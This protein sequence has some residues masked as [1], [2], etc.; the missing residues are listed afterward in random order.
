[1]NNCCC[2]EPDYVY[3]VWQPKVVK[4]RKAHRCVECKETIQPGHL[5]ER[6][7]A[8]GDGRCETTKTCARCANIRDEYFWCGWMTGGLVEDFRD[9]FGFDYRDGLPSDF[10]PCRGR[11]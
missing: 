4:A 9:C 11:R 7:F 5:Y 1:M 6:A 2:I 3:D 10:A 8:I